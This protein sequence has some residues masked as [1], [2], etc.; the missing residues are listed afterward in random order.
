MPHPKGQGNHTKGRPH[1]D[2]KRGDRR[3]GK[4][5]PAQARGIPPEWF[6]CKA[7]RTRD[8]KRCQKWRLKNAT[9][10]EFHGGRQ[11]QK[12]T[13]LNDMK[14]FYRNQLS[15]T[16]METVEAALEE[17]A[18]E[19]VSL[20]TE[21]AL[22]RLT[23]QESVKLFSAAQA[24]NN[25]GTKDAAAQL[26]VSALKNVQSVAESASR[27]Q[28]QSKDAV[29]I[30]SL[31][32]VVHQ[33]TRIIYEMVPDED[34]AMEIERRIKERVKLPDAGGTLLTPDEDVNS[35]DDSIPR[36]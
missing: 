31:K 12:R 14:E 35:M 4:Q 34:I 26:M 18:S 33:I 27:I 13:R 25:Q 20:F 15:A 36:E 28:A 16:L 10:C 32:V 5:H 7:N 30:G 2:G 21:L 19:Q 23:A 9:T 11:G 8:G 29:S 22:M 1:L 24:S 17:D 6:Q 3:K